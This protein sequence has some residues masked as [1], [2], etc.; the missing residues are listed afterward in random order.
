MCSRSRTPRCAP[1]PPAPSAAVL[2]AAA[3]LLAACATGG[4]PPAEPGPAPSEAS[5]PEAPADTPRIR[6]SS[7]ATSPAAAVRPSER[8][9]EAAATAELTGRELGSM[10]TFENPPLE[11]WRE[12]HDFEPS[13]GWLEDVRLSSLRYGEQCSSSFVSAEGLVMT[14]HHCARDCVEAVS[15]SDSDYVAEGFHAPERSREKV[16]PGL[17]LDQLVG[18]NEVTRAVRASVPEGAGD[19]ARA[20]ARRAARDSIVAACEE[21]SDLQCQVV[22]LYHGGQYQLYRYRRYSPVKL[23]FAPELQAGYFGGDYDNF[24]YPRFALDVAFVRAYRSDSTTAVRPDHWLEWDPGG[25]EEGELVFL[26][27]NPGS[28]SRLATVSQLQFEKEHRHPFLLDYFRELR[29]FLQEVAERGPEAAR[30]VRQRLFSVENTIKA[31]EGELDGLRDPS[32]MG[33]KIRW[34]DRFRERVRED[35]ALDRRYGDAWERMREIQED[36]LAVRARHRLEDAS[37]IGSPYVAA[38]S[39]LVT[40]IRESARPADRRSEDVDLEE[41][42]SRLRGRIPLQPGSGVRLL[43][44]RLRLADAWLPEGASL[45]RQAFRGDES[46]EEAARRLVEGTRVADA[47]FRTS[48]MEAGPAAL[49]TVSDPLVRLAAGMDRR[50]GELDARWQ[51]L[52]AAESVQEERLAE[53]LFAVFGTDLPPD[54]T[55]TLRISD[56]VVRRYPY[57]GTMAPARTSFYGLYERAANFGGEEPWNLPAAFRGARGDLDL[58][59]PLNFV[60]TNDITGGNSGSPVVDREGRAVGVA[61]DGNIQQLPNEYLFRTEQARTVSVH[62]AGI[63]EALREVYGADALVRELLG[64]APAD[65]VDAETSGASGDEGGGG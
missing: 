39:D 50:F 16:C 59:T 49:D 17:H 64:N 3:L 18:I 65:S 52:T 14:N 37:F 15:P 41:L 27:G 54:A 53:A 23:V 43:S 28:T 61:F 1:L 5:A 21:G 29:D 19:E 34:E 33:R 63:T 2:P 57:N 35:S 45:R 32:L 40:W 22:D 56:G 62:S 6:T 42:G 20:E 38:A 47:S 8:A 10:W 31:F 36:K 4:A 11:D 51:R 7:G 12:R 46:P 24:T 48:L 60:S 25:A 44:I 30:Q 58:S 55:F 26:T 9:R 13:D